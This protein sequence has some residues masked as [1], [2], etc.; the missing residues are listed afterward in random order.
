MNA[1]ALPPFL[2]RTEEVPPPSTLADEAL[3]ALLTLELVIQCRPSLHETLMDPDY[4][5]QGAYQTVEVASDSL[6]NAG[7]S[8]AYKV[9]ASPASSL[10]G[11]P[12]PE[13]RFTRLHLQV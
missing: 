9:L 3:P 4:H 2:V 12:I 10:F 11:R 7:E 5:P 6:P 1:T 8:L 13:N